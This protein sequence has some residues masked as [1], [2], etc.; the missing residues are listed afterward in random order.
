MGQN[1]LFRG[2]ATGLVIHLHGVIAA[3]DSLALHLLLLELILALVLEIN[4]AVFGLVL[5]SRLA[6]LLHTTHLGI[7]VNSCCRGLAN[8][9]SCG[10]ILYFLLIKLL[11]TVFFLVCVDVGFG[12]LGR[13]LGWCRGF[14]IPTDRLAR[15]LTSQQW[16]GPLS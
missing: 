5:L 11:C 7:A 10:S 12:L 13:E 14:G 16:L 4:T 2:V 1:C 9:S 6:C 15:G 8:L 3:L